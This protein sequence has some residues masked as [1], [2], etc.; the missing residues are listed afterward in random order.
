MQ[1]LHRALSKMKLGK[2]GGQS[3]IVPEMLL[4][5]GSD[6]HQALR[7]LLLDMWQSQ[8][9]VAELLLSWYLFPRRVIFVCATTGEA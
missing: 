5:S 4:H 6:L 8:S 7:Q 9:V 2:A 3:G 1:E